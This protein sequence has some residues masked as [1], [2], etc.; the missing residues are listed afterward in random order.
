MVDVQHLNTI[1]GIHRLVQTDFVKVSLVH[2]KS[3]TACAK[4]MYLSRTCAFILPHGSP[5]LEHK[6]DTFTK[7]VCIRVFVRQKRFGPN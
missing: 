5:L 6:R 7:P 1:P 4:F 2:L 3:G